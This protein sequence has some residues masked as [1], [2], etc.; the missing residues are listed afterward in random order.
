MARVYSRRWTSNDLSRGLS[1]RAVEAPNVML[2]LQ[3][4]IGDAKSMCLALCS[5]FREA[6]E[7]GQG[8]SG[9]HRWREGLRAVPWRMKGL[10][11]ASEVQE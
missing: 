2:L 10:G 11:S 4:I 6:A 5:G 7:A 9:A 3:Q 8:G 1:K